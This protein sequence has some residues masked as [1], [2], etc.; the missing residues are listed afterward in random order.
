MTTLARILIYEQRYD[1]ASAALEKA[2]P[3]EE[4]AYGPVSRQ[5][6]S[7]LNELGNAAM[8]RHQYD[9]AEPRFRRMLDIY[10][11]V[12]NNHHYLIGIALSNL[13][14]VYVGRKQYARARSFTTAKP[15]RFSRIH[16][17]PTI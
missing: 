8:N 13:A 5:V 15:F 16:S 4:H 6:A 7:A 9:L 12:Y 1:E 3:I 14:G 11:A 2:L 17:P 10:R